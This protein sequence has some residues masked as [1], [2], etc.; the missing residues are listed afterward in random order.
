MHAVF[1]CY[2]LDA[3]LHVVGIASGTGTLPATFSGRFLVS[4]WLA[5]FQARKY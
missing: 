5:A 2:F 4:D 3:V 1:H